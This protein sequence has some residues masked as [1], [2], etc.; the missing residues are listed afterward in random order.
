MHTTLLFPSTVSTCVGYLWSYWNVDVCEDYC[1]GPC[2]GHN[3][4]NVLKSISV[5]QIAR[6]SPIIRQSEA[7]ESVREEKWDD[8][9]GQSCVW[10]TT[11]PLPP[12]QV[13]CRQLWQKMLLWWQYWSMTQW[14]VG[15][16]SVHGMEVSNFSFASGSKTWKNSQRQ[17]IDY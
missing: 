4:G 12:K 17:E 15:L 16:A 9:G 7:T 3:S 6:I 5:N 13:C 14:L 2:R 10:H 1:K 11:H 8:A